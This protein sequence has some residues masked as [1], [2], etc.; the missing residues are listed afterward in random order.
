MVVRVRCSQRTDGDFRCDKVAVRES[1]L[2]RR[3]QTLL[4]GQWTWLRQ[5]H[6]AG[7]VM[8][9]APGEAAGSVADV[10]A[11]DVPGAVLALHTADC[12]PV[13]VAGD[14]VVGVAHAGWRGIVAGVLHEV[15]AAVRALAHP[16]SSGELRALL[17]PMIRPAAYEF[18]VDD[19][20]TVAHAVGAGVSGATSWGAP[21]LDLA[22]AVKASLHTVG[23]DRII[24]LRLDTADERF[25]SHR[26]RCEQSRMATAARLEPA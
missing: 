26:L 22:A 14:G 12:A 10:A 5:V 18:G 4:A 9:T 23:V 7:V 19:L 25:F 11:T 20:A 8:V 2:N 21:A 1:L 3:R 15:V 13:V 17:G 6:G 16:S 24:D